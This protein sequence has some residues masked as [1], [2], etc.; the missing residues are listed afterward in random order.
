[1]GSPGW[2]HCRRCSAHTHR[3]LPLVAA[4][5]PCLCSQGIQ[6][7]CSIH[8]FKPTPHQGEPVKCRKCN[9]LGGKGR[10]QTG[11]EGK[12]I[13]K[14]AGSMRDQL[15]QENT[16]FPK[17]RGGKGWPNACG[18]CR[19]SL[20]TL[21]AGS[22]TEGEASGQGLSLAPRQLNSSGITSLPLANSGILNWAAHYPWAQRVREDT[23]GA[24]PLAW[25][26]ALRLPQHPAA[27]SWRI[28]NS[29]ANSSPN[30]GCVK[31]GCHWKMHIYS[32]GSVFG[33]LRPCP[34]AD[35]PSSQHPPA[36]LEQLHGTQCLSR[37]F[38][39]FSSLIWPSSCSLAGCLDSFV[40]IPGTPGQA[41][42]RPSP[43]KC[44][45]LGQHW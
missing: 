34:P 31:G 25:S 18:S 9:Q 5:V 21:M 22:G 43:R 40:L 45:C 7:N 32:F 24:T 42:G 37:P 44:L 1:M 11:L 4:A 23:T 19:A 38:F 3:A 36:G 10:P 14:C 29:Y 28:H 35:P 6:R 13:K 17:E 15:S 20:S 2:G 41:P 33:M 12:G 16:A 27:P 39:I 26:P 30:Q 8:R